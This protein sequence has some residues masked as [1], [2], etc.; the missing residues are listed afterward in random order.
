MFAGKQAGIQPTSFEGVEDLPGERRG[1]WEIA[2]G[3]SEAV[4]TEN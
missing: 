2:G 1:Q 3:G 4:H